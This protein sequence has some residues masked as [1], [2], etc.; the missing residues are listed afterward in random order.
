M[1]VAAE[2][3]G[4]A[5]LLHHFEDERKVLEA[6]DEGVVA[7]LAEAAADAH[8]ILGLDL[9]LADREHR[10]LEQRLPQLVPTAFIQVRKR[11]AAHFGAERSRKRFDYHRATICQNESQS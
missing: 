6:G 1:P 5:L 11:Y 3:D 2:V 4:L 9:L 7:R 8:E 10:V